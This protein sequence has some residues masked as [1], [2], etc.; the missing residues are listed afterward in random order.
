M[1]PYQVVWRLVGRLSG[2]SFGWS[3]VGSVGRHLNINFMLQAGYYLEKSIYV[4]VFAVAGFIVVVFLFLFHFTF[5]YSV[6]PRT[7]NLWVFQCFI[8]PQIIIQGILFY[9][10]DDGFSSSFVFQT[11]LLQLAAAAAASTALSSIQTQ[12]VVLDNLR[13]KKK[14]LPSIFV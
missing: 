6:A 7:Y 2:L 13:L 5:L 14:K 8:I 1:F 9:N 10:D 4:F 12:M 3:V 11:F